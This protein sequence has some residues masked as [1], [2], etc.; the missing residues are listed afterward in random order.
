MTLSTTLIALLI[1]AIGLALL[2]FAA[3]WMASVVGGAQFVQTPNALFPTIAELAS[4]SPGECFIELGAGRGDLC[5][6]VARTTGAK[7]VGID[8]NPLLTILGRWLSRNQPD[9]TLKLQNIY[10]EPLSKA[11][12]VYCYLLPHMLRKLAPKFNA[13]LAPG[14]RVICYAFPLPDRTPIKT[15]PRTATTGRIFLYEY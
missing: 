7:A 15:L 4:L 1:L 11:S 6:Y 5:R 3:S 12:A 14:T 8:V 10:H 9:V 2:F 13:E